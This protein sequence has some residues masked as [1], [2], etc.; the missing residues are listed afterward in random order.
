MMNPQMLMSRANCARAQAGEICRQED[1]QRHFA[2]ITPTASMREEFTLKADALR[3]EFLAMTRE[4]NRLFL[5]A[6]GEA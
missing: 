2:K 4:A 1:A 5:E 3:K 6:K